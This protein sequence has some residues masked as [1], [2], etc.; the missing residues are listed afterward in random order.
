MAMGVA[1]KTL[2]GQ[3]VDSDDVKHAVAALRS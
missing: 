2:A 3:P 1:M